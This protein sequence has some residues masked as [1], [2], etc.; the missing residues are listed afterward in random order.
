MTK[1]TIRPSLIAGPLLFL[2]G[3]IGLGVAFFALKPPQAIVDTGSLVGGPFELVDQDGKTF[4]EKNLDGKPFLVFF[5]F[6]HC[7]DICPTKLF[8]IS[9]VLNLLEKDMPDLAALF[10]SVDA[11]RDTPEA[12]KRYVSSF[13]PKIIG[14]TGDQAKID[15]AVKA[16]RAYAKKVPTE[17]G[18]Y[19][20][21]HTSLVYLM[22]REGKFVTSLDMNRSDTDIAG[23]IKDRL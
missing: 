5:G 9:Q 8:E 17:S 3:L 21:D 6:T 13:N 14:L 18:S 20:M 19:T 23:K 10:I 15:A 1:K 22:N 2:A 11:E 12:M 4:T 7:P 16:Y